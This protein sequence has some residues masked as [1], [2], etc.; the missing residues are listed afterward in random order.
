MLVIVVVCSFI[1]GERLSLGP[2]E[3]RLVFMSVEAVCKVSDQVDLVSG[4]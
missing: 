1:P 4:G 3:R 2:F